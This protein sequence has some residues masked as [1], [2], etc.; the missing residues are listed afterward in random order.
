MGRVVSVTRLLLICLLLPLQ[1]SAG[2][3]LQEEG[4]GLLSLNYFYYGTDTAFDLN[5]D[6]TAV[7]S[8][9][10][11]EL[12]PYVEYG[13]LDNLTIGA[14]P[15]LQVV[16]QDV[17][18]G[19]SEHNVGLAE[20]EIFARVKLYEE[21]DWALSLQPLFKL[22]SFYRDDD[23]VKAGREESDAELMLLA[24]Y[25]FPL[26]GQQHYVTGGA[27]YRTRFGALDDQ[28]RAHIEAGFRFLNDFTLMPEF[29]WV[30]RSESNGDPFLSVSGQ[31]NYDLSK[32]QLSALYDL[33]E[34]YSVQAG[35][36]Q[37]VDGRNTGADGGGLLSLWMRW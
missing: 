28:Y 13:L 36:F 22:P 37:H 21:A 11:H 24:G 12:N 29:R 18:G 2:A 17:A 10:K 26:F 23:E 7:P 15:F 16:S 3:W 5:G 30:E 9:N 35:L 31:N 33:N 20:T 19:G 1:A 8:F 34:R 4:K 25:S 27:G 6:K 14:S 32:I